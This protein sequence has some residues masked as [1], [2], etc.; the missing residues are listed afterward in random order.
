MELYNH[1]L[2]IGRGQDKTSAELEVILSVING[3]YPLKHD[4]KIEFLNLYP[5]ERVTRYE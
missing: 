4:G 2:I 3:E 1:H 5:T